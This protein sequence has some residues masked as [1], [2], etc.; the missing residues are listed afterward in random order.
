MRHAIPRPFTSSTTGQHG[1]V[2]A[3]VSAIA[4]GAACLVGV[5]SPAS[6]ATVTASVNCGATSGTVSTAS[7]TVTSND[8]LTVT[9]NGCTS[10]DSAAGPFATGFIGA[11]TNINGTNKTVDYTGSTASTAGGTVLLTITSGSKTF[12]VVQPQAPA[13]PAFTSSTPSP[14]TMNRAYSYTFVASGS[15]APTFTL[16]SRN[17]LPVTFNVDSSGVLS[18]TPTAAGTYTFDVKATNVSGD[19][20]V[21]ATLSVRPEVTK[22]T[23]CHRT[24]A[25]TNPYVLITVSVNAVINSS[26]HNEHDTT[27][28]NKTN[29]QNGTTGGSGPFNPSFS[30]PSNKKWWGDIIPPFSY[31]AQGNS[32]PAGSFA[33]LNWSPNWAVPGANPKSNNTEYWIEDANFAAAINGATNDAPYRAAVEKCINLGTP[34]PSTEA[35]GVASPT[36]LF[37]KNRDNG[38]PQTEAKDDLDELG[39]FFSTPVDAT[40]INNIANT[41]RASVVTTSPTNVTQTSGT[42]NGTLNALT[43]ATWSTYSFNYYTGTDS[44]TSTGTTTAGGTAG[45]LSKSADLPGLTCGTTYTYQIVG[46]DSTGATYYGAWETFTTSACGNNNGGGNNNGNNG[47]GNGNNR[48][49]TPT[50]TPTPSPSTSSLNRRQPALPSQR[51]SASPTPSQSPSN[52]AASS[53]TST[54]RPTPTGSPSPTRDPQPPVTLDPTNVI[55]LDPGDEPL[56]GTTEVIDP[57]TGE[58]TKEVVDPSGTWKVNPNGTITFTPAPGFVGTA[59]LNV[60][61]SGR[62]GKLYIQPMSVRVAA[63][64]RIAIVTGDVPGSISAGVVRTSEETPEMTYAEFRR[65]TR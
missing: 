16:A 35:Q 18:G 65:L 56:P 54:P 36:N 20:T 7:A 52:G 48:E 9:Y 12:T 26:G 55:P 42:I 44:P 5:A 3:I 2:L 53:P 17:T 63:T 45:P 57:K 8:T 21:T 43:G 60:Q 10:Q 33:G 13:A 14:A 1:H 62:S 23:I 15:P 19:A 40:E 58:P 31:P 32:Y 24:R 50:P 38:V 28:T 25:T 41:Y 61:L 47:N 11:G 46:T 59:T 34:G 22:V 30:Y 64:S 27:R 4:L 49:A 39:P 37:K 29:P 51:P 6:A